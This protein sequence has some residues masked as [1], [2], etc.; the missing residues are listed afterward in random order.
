MFFKIKFMTSS[1]G[2]LESSV[3]KVV[4]GSIN[5]INTSRLTEVVYLNSKCVVLDYWRRQ[6]AR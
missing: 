5:I 4:S 1:V 2:V 6:Q 3:I